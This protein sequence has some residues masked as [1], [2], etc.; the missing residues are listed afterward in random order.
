MSVPNAIHINPLKFWGTSYVDLYPGSTV[1]MTQATVSS[2]KNVGMG[3]CNIP[4]WSTSPL[5]AG[6]ASTETLASMV[7][8]ADRSGVSPVVTPHNDIDGSLPP[9]NPQIPLCRDSLPAPIL[10]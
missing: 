5:K 7:A 6:S 8:L 1:S 3:G 4:V 9:S 2:C 10:S